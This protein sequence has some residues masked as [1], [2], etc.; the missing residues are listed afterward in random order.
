LTSQWPGIFLLASSFTGGL[1]F[2]RVQLGFYSGRGNACRPKSVLCLAHDPGV[3]AGEN[4]GNNPQNGTD[5]A[6]DDGIAGLEVRLGSEDAV[7]WC[8]G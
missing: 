4:D 5:D 1:E 3:D 7:D 8:D 2:D 6:K